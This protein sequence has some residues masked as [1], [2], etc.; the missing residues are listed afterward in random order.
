MDHEA[1]QRFDVGQALGQRAEGSLLQLQGNLS[2]GL[3]LNSVLICLKICIIVLDV[4]VSKVAAYFMDYLS[5][6]QVQA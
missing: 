3:S 2:L 1:G 4:L 5:S 6:S